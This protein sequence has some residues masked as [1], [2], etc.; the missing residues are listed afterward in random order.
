MADTIFGRIV[1]GEI[2]VETVYEDDICLAFADIA[3]QAPVHLLVIPR[4]PF[5]D[6]TQ[7]D[8]ATLG[9]VFAVAAKLGA[10]KCPNGF[11]LVTNI[12]SGGGQSVAHL[13]IHVLGGRALKWPPG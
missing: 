5:E 12:G 1:R 13:H 7:A 8:A 3:P 11:R 4:E 6:A 2:P 9:H 10:E